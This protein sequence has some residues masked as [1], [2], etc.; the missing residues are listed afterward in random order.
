ME[1]ALSTENNLSNLI[2]SVNVTDN[3]SIFLH[4]GDYCQKQLWI[5]EENLNYIKVEEFQRDSIDED[6]IDRTDEHTQI[7][8][9]IDEYTQ[10]MIQYYLMAIEEGSVIAMNKLGRYYQ[11]VGHNEMLMVEYYKMAIINNSTYAMRKM[12]HYAMLKMGY[13]WNGRSNLDIM[14]HFY[15]MA[16]SHGDIKSA[17]HLG[18]Y[19]QYYEPNKIL[20][21]KY[22]LIAI[23]NISHFYKGTYSIHYIQKTGA[24]EECIVC[25]ET[26]QMYATP[27]QKH[28]I[29]IDCS[30]ML[31]G[32][33][34][35]M[36]RGTC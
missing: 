9:R 23:E 22:Y 29:C 26:K 27:C 35:P 12:G 15:K 33:P 16:F 20:M 13:D 11:D 6:Y 10:L 30:I 28:S 5:E 2:A 25:Y 19:Y 21:K 7:Q 14:K 34:C 18:R 32:E 24:D 1:S 17:F 8:N 31:I 3:D 4:M 36:C